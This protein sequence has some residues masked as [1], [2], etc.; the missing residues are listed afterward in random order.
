MKLNISLRIKV[1]VIAICFIVT[2]QIFYSF[3]NVQ[4]FRESYVE[5]LREKCRTSGELLKNDVEFVLNLNIPITK[6]VKLEKTLE[7]IL[8]T[9]PEL[10]FLEITDLSN[11][12]LYYADHESIGRIEAGTQQSRTLDENANQTLQRFHLTPEM[13]DTVLPVY[14]QKKNELVG[15]IHMRLSPTLVAGKSRDI[16]FDMITVILTSLLITFE[17]LTFFVAY[18][19]GDPLENTVRNIRRSLHRSALLPE[20]RFLLMKNLDQVVTRFNDFMYQFLS[21]FQPFSALYRRLCDSQG[22]LEHLFQKQTAQVK[23]LLST[24]P[25]QQNMLLT[26]GLE[27]MQ[28]GLV[29]FR[30]RIDSLIKHVSPNILSPIPQILSHEQFREDDEAVAEQHLPYMYIRPIIFLFIM[31]DGFA[32]S[33]FPLYVNELYLPMFGLSKEVILG[34]P[35]SIFMFAFAISMPVS[36]RW[37]DRAGAIKPLFTGIFLDAVGLILTAISQNILHVILARVVTAIGYGMVMMASQ[38]FVISNT[39]SRNRTLGMASLLA[40]FFGGDICGTVVGGMLADRIGYGNVFLVSGLIS[41][42]ALI[43]AV[44]LFKSQFSTH[45]STQDHAKLSWKHVYRALKDKDFF[46]VVVFQ[47]IPAKI[48]LVGFLFYFVPLYLKRLQTLQ[49][50]IGRVIMCYGVMLVFLGPLFSKVFHQEA[51]KKYYIL[52]GGLITGLSM[53][54]FHTVSG[55]LP[56]LFLVT[57]LGVAHTFSVSSQSSYITETAVFQELGTGIGMGIFRSFERVGSIIGPILAGFLIARVGY[58]QAVV[59]LG[60]ISLVCSFFYFFTLLILGRRTKNTR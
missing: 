11:D 35:I 20:D 54:S 12:V 21:T 30:E 23:S 7:E 14:F 36:G 29:T 25:V 27:R 47:A 9:T 3:R 37:S 4:S 31:A 59:V 32:V 41:L 5:S 43:C 17:F 45:S 1:F 42:F 44:F 52:T 40:A 49:S 39:T 53:I 56:T 10:E 38:Q 15:Y 51:H 28:L 58:E 33:F 34:L 57:M 60:T 6:L 55:F 50:N 48:I 46:A 16:L 8:K 19:I 26:A 18:S 22:E 24:P 13:T 2:G